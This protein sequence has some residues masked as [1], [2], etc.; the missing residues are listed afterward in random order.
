MVPYA[1]GGASDVVARIYGKELEGQLGK[2]V[3]IVNRTGASGAIGLES[4]KNARPDGYTMS[5]MPVECTMLKA[6]GIAEVSSDDFKFVARVMTIPAAITVA[7]DAPWNTLEE[8]LDYARE[9]PGSVLIGNSGSGSIWH[10]AAASLA[11]AAGVEFTHVPFDGAA[12]AIAG[13]LGHNITAVA[14]SPAE[15]KPNVDAGQFKVLAVIGDNR[16]SVVPDVQTT[17]ELGWDVTAMGWGGFAVPKDTPAEVVQILSDAS[18]K[19]VQSETLQNLLRERG[20]EFAPLT[21]EEMD[22][23]AKEQLAQYSVLIPELMGDGQ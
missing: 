15:V 18:M 4:V 11:R 20:F 22:A 13:L 21:G 2:P 6:L 7:A 23:F 10:V 5:Y 9:N 14:V 17:G 19:V 1:P 3:V 16:S 8:F 12:P